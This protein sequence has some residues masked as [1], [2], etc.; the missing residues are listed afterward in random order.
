MAVKSFFKF[1]ISLLA[2]AAITVG[3]LVFSEEIKNALPSSIV[4][5]WFVDN[6][7][8]ISGVVFGL[9][10][11]LLVLELIRNAKK[12][13]TQKYFNVYK[14]KH[15]TVTEAARLF[16][17]PAANPTFY[18]RAKVE[19]LL[20][21]YTE[22]EIKKAG[23][24]LK[25]PSGVGK[26][27]LAY[28]VAT[29]GLNGR[30]FKS[31]LVPRDVTPLE[32]ACKD[33]KLK[34][35]TKSILIFDNFE[36][37]ADV[38]GLV[39]FIERNRHRCFYVATVRGE[40][41]ELLMK[42]SPV[43]GIPKAAVARFHEIKLTKLPPDEA[44]EAAA[45][46]GAE[47][48]GYDTDAPPDTF[49]WLVKDLTHELKYYEYCKTANAPEGRILE[50]LALAVFSGYIITPPTTG[51]VE[52]LTRDILGYTC[53]VSQGLANLENAE[54]ITLREGS[55][56]CRFEYLT[57]IWSKYVRVRVPP[58]SRIRAAFARENDEGCRI[59]ALLLAE[60]SYEAGDRELAFRAVAA[61]LEA[62]PN[63][64]DTHFTA[65]NIYA[66]TDGRKAAAFYEE[67]LRINSEYTY[68]HNN[69][70]NLLGKLGRD[71]EAEGHYREGLRINPED[72]EAHYNYAVLLVKLARDE[73]AEGHYRE[74]LRINPGLL[75]ANWSFSEFLAK[76]GRCAEAKAYAA[77]FFELAPEHPN[78]PYLKKVLDELCP[79]A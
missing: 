32:A 29:A 11:F 1:I 60:I 31:I 24:L 13:P 14:P 79:D 3:L 5:N 8:Y 41:A 43:G 53:D 15:F 20:K 38:E 6:V 78:V 66:E 64:A 76:I 70:A 71:E 4:I 56:Y 34:L 37:F 22:P 44:S 39:A 69:Y 67:A 54:R 2:N 35:P 19:Q 16:F 7:L 51:E 52:K 28:Q 75:E 73:E 72:A 25:G 30:K 50:A 68:A 58:A 47:A 10:I 62:F 18:P 23:I 55:Y 77:R 27:R 21:V 59:A 36:D 48:P 26:S 17:M 63:Y 57:A 40:R 9:I 33:D 61:A 45:A 42:D 49:A 65:G 46:L 12:K 74:A